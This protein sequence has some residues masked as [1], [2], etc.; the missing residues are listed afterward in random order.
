MSRMDTTVKPGNG[1]DPVV[2]EL[3]YDSDCAQAVPLRD[4]V[5]SCL[6]G[7]GVAWTFREEVDRG[8]LSP[9]LLVDGRD[10]AGHHAPATGCRLD[11]PE[12]AQICL[13]LD[14]ALLRQEG[15]MT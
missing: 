1:P 10:V 8:R 9:T 4:L 7:R 15:G 13:A 2:V 3:Y 6:A 5:L 11:R 12:A 14:R